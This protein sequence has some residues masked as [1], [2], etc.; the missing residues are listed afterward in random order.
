MLK[1][2]V[3]LTLAAFAAAAFAQV[4]ATGQAPKGI[5]QLPP[6]QKP[7]SNNWLL[8]ADNDTDRFKKLQIYLRGF[9]QPMQEVGQRYLAFYE[10][11]KERNWGL[12][13]YHWD[14]IK[15]AINGGLMKRPASAVWN[16]RAA[17]GK[18]NVLMSG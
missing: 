8:D 2:T 12:A 1:T 5:K 11:I 9:D 4:P 17:P 18:P 10:A 7:A 16:R 15:V 14:K 3:A 13:D 6:Q